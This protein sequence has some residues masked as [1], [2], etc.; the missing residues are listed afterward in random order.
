MSLGMRNP[1]SG[2]GPRKNW[3]A[4]KG[5]AKYGARPPKA[6]QTESEHKCLLLNCFGKRSMNYEL[7][8]WH[9]GRPKRRRKNRQTA[10]TGDLRPLPRRI[11]TRPIQAR[12]PE[13]A[14]RASS[15]RQ[16]SNWLHGKG[17]PFVSRGCSLGLHGSNS[18]EGCPFVSTEADMAG[19]RFKGC[20]FWVPR[21]LVGGRAKRWPKFI[22]KLIL[23]CIEKS[24]YDPRF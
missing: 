15:S 9:G 22:S 20:P 1:V 14:R 18:A 11:P 8:E 21:V 12:R 3:D 4:R 13:A 6:G 24:C 7:L 2:R 17:C 5:S 19:I 23:R 16:G 10:S